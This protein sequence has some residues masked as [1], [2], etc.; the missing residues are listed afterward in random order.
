MKFLLSL[1]LLLLVSLNAIGQEQKTYTVKQGETL[2]AISKQLNVSVAE[3]Q[4][5]NNLSDNTLSIGDE[6]VYYAVEVDTTQVIETS[7]SLIEITTPQQ[8]TFYVVRSGDNLTRIAREHNMTIDE[9]RTLNNL[10]GDLLS[11]GQRLSV[12]KLIDSV[13]PSVSEFSEESSPQGSFAVYTVQ[14]GEYTNQLLTRFKMTLP[15]IQELNPEIN[16][17]ALDVNQK[18]TILLPPS[19]SYSNPYEPKANLQDLGVVGAISYKNSEFGNTTT[20]G[21]LYNPE[22]LTAAHS[23]I[24]LGS[25]IFVENSSTKNG[26]F[27]RINDRVTGSGLK[28]SAKAYRI[29][30][31]D[32]NSNPTVSIYIES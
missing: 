14:Q 31:L 5:W 15:E 10:N 8:N 30:G 13:A 4:Q 2:Y 26:I 6:L 27:V 17:D 9:L 7:A 24:A 11:I 21:E 20:N 1:I 32:E 23:N 25:I 19:R 3:L 29:L 12:R 16:F 22:Q 18:I 28:L